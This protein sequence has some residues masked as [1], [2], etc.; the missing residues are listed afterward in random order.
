MA[1]KPSTEND[2]DPTKLVF[3]DDA[4]SAVPPVMVI[5]D[6]G[7]AVS[8]DDLRAVQGQEPTADQDESDAGDED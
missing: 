7:S 6:D 5:M 4:D 1:K 2:I 8:W 3:V